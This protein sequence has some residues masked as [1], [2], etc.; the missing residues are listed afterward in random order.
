MAG[1]SRPNLRL[2]FTAVLV[3]ALMGICSFSYWFLVKRTTVTTDDA[4]IDGDMVDI[5]PQVGGKLT[6]VFVREGD[7]VT[8]GQPLFEL[9]S[10]YLRSAVEKA[11]LDLATAQKS[12]AI[13]ETEYQKAL[14]G[15]R[16]QEIRIAETSLKSAESA[17]AH[18][19]TEWQRID[20]LHRDKSVTETEWESARTVRTTAQ[21]N[22]DNAREQLAL[23]KS[24]SRDEDRQIAR[25]KVDLIQA[26]IASAEA[27][28]KS[29]RI[30]LSYA[31]VAAPFDGIV[32]RQWRKPGA[33]ITQGTSVLT[34]LDTASLYVSANI[35]E[36]Y[37]NRIKP[38]QTVTC[39][40]DAY[41]GKQLSGHVD[42]ILQAANS[43]FSLIPSEGVSGTYIKVSQRIPVRITLD[44][45]SGIDSLVLGPG[46]SVVARIKTGASSG[47]RKTVA[48]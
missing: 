28:V 7:V 46:M 10:E 13:A 41:P 19:E 26:Q 25:E 40:V 15:P 39:S 20:A 8:S 14:N 23:L 16:T 22:C 4:R 38:G 29:A 3:L 27:V 47:E 9:D 18:V 31:S 2:I 12:L 11:E 36:K 34:L 21:Y 43:E 6:G 17:L 1:S 45:P 33:T 44:K 5:A 48:R 37:L 24:G 42:R 35:E 30:N 32:V